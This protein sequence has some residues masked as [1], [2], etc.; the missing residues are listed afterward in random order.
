[1]TQPQT[2]GQGNEVWRA[3]LDLGFESRGGRTVLASRR[4]HGPL[5][6]QRPFYPEGERVCHVYLLHPPGGLVGGDELVIDVAVNAGA[7]ALLTT[8][9][10]GKFYRS[11]GVVARQAQRLRVEQA[12]TLEWLPQESILFD[13]AHAELSTRVELAAGACFI[14]WEITVLGRPGAGERFAHGALRQRIELWREGQPLYLERARYEEGAAVLGAPWGLAGHAVSGSLLCVCDGVE[15]LEQVREA[16]APAAGL[17]SA[18]RLDG[19]MVCRYLGDHADE[20]RRCFETV[21]TVLR[22]ALLQRPACA[23]RI[24]AT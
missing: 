13:G 18:T 1:M 12:A 22:P 16:V 20:A 6:V 14:G 4:H 7:S 2:R 19:M 23:P 15:L 24:W 8:P 11:N 21:W 17:F 3:R 9:A 5:R 10:A